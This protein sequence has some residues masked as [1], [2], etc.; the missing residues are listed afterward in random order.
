ML[1]SF[2]TE[3][4]SKIHGVPDAHRRMPNQ[5]VG[6]TPEEMI[7]KVRPGGKE[8]MSQKRGGKYVPNRGMSVPRAGGQAE[9]RCMFQVNVIS[10]ALYLLCS[11][12][13][14]APRTDHYL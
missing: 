1:Y 12:P 5:E 7:F 2:W 10:K 4:I 14:N 8:R 9:P 3:L 11:R 6:K 13:A